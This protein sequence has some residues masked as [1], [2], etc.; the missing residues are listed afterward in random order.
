[1]QKSH[2]GLRPLKININIIALA[3]EKMRSQKN[4][5]LFQI[6]FFRAQPFSQLK[7][8]V[9]LNKWHPKGKSRWSQLVNCSLSGFHSFNIGNGK[10]SLQKIMD[11]LPFSISAT[12]NK[13][14]K[15]STHQEA[16]TPWSLKRDSQATCTLA[17]FV[18]SQCG[19]GSWMGWWLSK[20]QMNRNSATRMEWIWNDERFGKLLLNVKVVWQTW[21]LIPVFLPSGKLITLWWNTARWL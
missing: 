21:F 3:H 7:Q 12:Q 19:F 11:F 6:P 17:W 2:L 18:T 14:R 16:S 20:G 9:H 15:I 10:W 4:M 1:M 8:V 13:P 5:I